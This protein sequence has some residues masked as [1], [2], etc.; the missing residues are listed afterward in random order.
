S[1]TE[2]PADHRGPP[3]DTHRRPR[4][5][6]EALLQDRRGGAP[7][8][9]EALRA[10]LLGDR[11]QVGQAP[12]DPLAAAPLQE[13]RRRALAADSPPALRQALHDRGGPHPPA[14]P[15]PRRGPGPAPA[16]SPD[17]TRAGGP[18]K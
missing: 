10:P 7:G 17:R 2:A 11:V 8:G 6:R 5:P 13:A 1:T 9:G 14:R 15:G 18:T 16:R 4:D 12:E 3:R